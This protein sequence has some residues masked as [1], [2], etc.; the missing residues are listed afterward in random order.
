MH[1]V[2][3]IYYIT[4]NNIYLIILPIYSYSIILIIYINYHYN[5]SYY[6]YRSLN[7]ILYPIINSYYLQR[8]NDSWK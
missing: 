7:F 8:E 1:Y 2:T 3:F 6:N 4:F 5:I